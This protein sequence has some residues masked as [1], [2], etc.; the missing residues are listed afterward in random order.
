VGAFIGGPIPEALIEPAAVGSP[1]PEMA[2]F[3]TPDDYIRAPLEATYQLAWEAV[4]AYW[5]DV[6]SAPP[7]S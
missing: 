7:S 2:L 1:L 5:R 3:L 4:P 6:L